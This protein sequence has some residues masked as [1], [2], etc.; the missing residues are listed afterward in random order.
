[1]VGFSLDFRGRFSVSEF[2]PPSATVRLFL[3]SATFLMLPF[4]VPRSVLWVGPFLARLDS[5]AAPLVRR[6][7]EVACWLVELG[8]LVLDAVALSSVD[9]RCPVEASLRLWHGPACPLVA[10]WSLLAF[11]SNGQ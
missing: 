8:I 11:S 10:R 4:G 2:L 3:I 5:G 6:S 1:M 7:S 9:L